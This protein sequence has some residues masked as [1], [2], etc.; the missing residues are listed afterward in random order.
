MQV[1]F[2]SRIC[3]KKNLDGALRILQGVEVPLDFHIYGPAEDKAYWRLCEKEVQKLPA[4]VSATYHGAIAH[5]DVPAM[6]RSQD[7]FFLPT[8]GENFGHV[9][10]EAMREGCPALI[11]NTTAFRNLEQRGAGWDLAPD[12]LAGFRRALQ[13]CA[14]M[15]PEEW[16]RW[17]DGARRLVADITADGKI[18]DTYRAAFRR[19][20]ARGNVARAA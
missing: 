6:M 7:L 14:A 18:T 1:V 4:N 11:T 13:K 3:P 16:L 20:V 5:S 19:V 17:S 10:V 8:R 15:S 9:I 12:D 2:L